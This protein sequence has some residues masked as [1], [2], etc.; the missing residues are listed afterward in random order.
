MFPIS[1]ALTSANVVPSVRLRKHLKSHRAFARGSVN[2]GE[3]SFKLRS[4]APGQPWV[5]K[6]LC[7]F[8]TEDGGR[9]VECESCKTWQHIYCYYESQIDPHFCTDCIKAVDGT[10]GTDSSRACASNDPISLQGL[11]LE[12]A[13]DGS[14]KVNIVPD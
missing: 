7:P 4:Y 8:D 5:I 9:S 12:S 2:R 13:E 10:A 14:G 11:S 6:C 3:Y 1:F